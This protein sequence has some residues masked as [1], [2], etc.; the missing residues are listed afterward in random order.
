MSIA[1]EC[2]FGI[3][4]ELKIKIETASLKGLKEDGMRGSDS[5]IVDEDQ[6]PAIRGVL[7]GEGEAMQWKEEQESEE[8]P[9]VRH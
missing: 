7:F 9:V 4:G 5:E 1:L 3:I 6:D 2:E 8:D